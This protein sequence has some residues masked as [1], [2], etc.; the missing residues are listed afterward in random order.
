MHS[1]VLDAVRETGEARVIVVMGDPALPE[2][3]AWD[4]RR[5]GAANA[6]LGRMVMRAAPRFQVGRQYRLFP[7]LA[8]KVDEQ[9][10]RELAACPTVEAV[11]PDREL[12]AAL[13][14]SGPLFVQ[15]TVE[16]AGYDGG[17]VGIAMVP[18]GVG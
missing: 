1:R 4:W 3:R 7:F 8:G 11:Y 6:E 14:D 18:V 15:P 9:G 13:D 2:A 10:L 17:G 16:T 5:R 12:R